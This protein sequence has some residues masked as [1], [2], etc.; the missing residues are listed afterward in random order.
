MG[1]AKSSYLQG[2]HLLLILKFDIHFLSLPQKCRD[3]KYSVAFKGLPFEPEKRQVIYVENLYDEH[4]NALIRD[5]Y[6]QIKWIFGRANLDFVYLPMFFNDEETKEKV[7]YYAPYLTSEIIEKAELRSSYLLGYMSHQENREK[8]ASSL[9]YSP[10][11]DDEEW[12]FQGQTFDIEGDGRSLT[13]QWFEEVAAEIEEEISALQ[14]KRDRRYDEDLED[15]VL[16]RSDDDWADD[17]PKAEYSSTPSL[18]DK[19]R[20]KLKQIGSSYL[21]EEEGTTR[22]PAPS[23]LDEIFD[24][25]VRD[26]MEDLER[27]I[28]RL[29]LLGIPLAVIVEFVTK[30]ET[31][32]RLR[33]TDGNKILLPDYGNREVQM[34]PL[35]KA[36]FFLFLNHPEGI[37][38]K[39]LE[40]HHH[41]LAN[42]YLQTSNRK[43][44]TPGMLARINNLEYPGNDNINVVLSR[45]NKYFRTTIDEHLAKN[46]YIVGKPGEPYK[47]A[48]DKIIIEWEDDDE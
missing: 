16:Y 28:E 46:Y 33:L 39:R 29:R 34:G 25:D 23:S 27:N 6:Q 13:I 5:N 2:L 12:I 18:W 48:L 10:K 35:C 8:I 45:I 19:F 44:L 26:T 41:E 43:E 38:L 40:E 32:S 9:L 20:R 4:I 31:I 1:N 17:E 36:M 22:K 47:I 21:E 7:L 14:P 37:V 30:Y 42:Y 15:D 24:E 11:K 3:M